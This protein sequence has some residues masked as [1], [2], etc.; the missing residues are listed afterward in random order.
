MT[1]CFSQEQAAAVH[2]ATRGAEPGQVFVS[3]FIGRLDDVGVH[4]IDLI[5]NILMMYQQWD[6]HVWVL[7]ASVRNLDHLLGCLRLGVPCIT[8]PRSVLELWHTYGTSTD[9]SQ[10]PF[11]LSSGDPL[12]YHDLHD[13]DWVL[14]NIQHP[15]TEKGLKKFADDWNQ[16][17]RV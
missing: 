3:P 10:Y 6:S 9:P 13:Q 7:A 16:M 12:V 1:L 15:L 8:A 5:K 17:L 14:M 2:A 4:G 11:T